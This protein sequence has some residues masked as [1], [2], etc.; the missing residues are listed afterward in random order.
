MYYV[1]SLSSAT[2]QERGIVGYRELPD[3]FHEFKSLA[4]NHGAVASRLEDGSLAAVKG[5]MT[6]TLSI[7]TT[8]ESFPCR[9]LLTCMEE[10]MDRCFGILI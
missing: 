4:R 2:V 8:A 1:F 9:R 7:G 6:I 3:L 10:M 5:S